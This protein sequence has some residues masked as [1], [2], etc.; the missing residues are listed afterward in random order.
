MNAR[1]LPVRRSTAVLRLL[2][3]AALLLAMVLVVACGGS[4]DGAVVDR[5]PTA[6]PV[7]ASLNGLYW[8]AAQTRLYLTDDNANVVCVWDDGADFPVFADLPP[9]QAEQRATL[10]QITRGAD[11]VLY[12]TRFGFS[13][14]GAIVAVPDNGDAHDLTGLDVTRRRLGITPTPDDTLLTGW[15]RGGA[16]G[17]DSGAVSEVS[18][19]ADGSASERDLIV[20]LNKPTGLALVGDALLV[21]D[22]SEDVLR[23]YALSELRARSAPALAA[24]GDV[25]IRF[26]DGEK[27]DLMTAGEDGTLYIGTGAGNL[28]AISLED[29][30]TPLATDWSG[31][32]RGLAWDGAAGRLFGAVMAADEEDR[33][34]VRIV[35]LD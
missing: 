13:E 24:D 6:L 8:D 21:A 32:I 9:M 18:V 27:P 16:A 35:P 5:G 17:N 34:T 26:D 1:F 23:R 30:R 2:A 15:F 31:G 11:G 10:G 14:Y 25:V 19:R 33:P 3:T 7:D 28:Y 22:Q 4:D 12:T 29:E 20:G